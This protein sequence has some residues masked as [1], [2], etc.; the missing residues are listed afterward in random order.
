ML[1]GRV[2]RGGSQEPDLEGDKR[3]TKTGAKFT[4]NMSKK[5]V[6]RYTSKLTKFFM[7][8]KEMLTF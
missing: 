3:R 4:K 2:T 5:A 6:N 7:K 1:I 8:I